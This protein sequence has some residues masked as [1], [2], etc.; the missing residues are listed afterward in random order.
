MN[1]L[2]AR[3]VATRM[4]FFIISRKLAKNNNK[5]TERGLFSKI[6]CGKSC[7]LLKGGKLIAWEIDTEG[8]SV[9]LDC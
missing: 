3:R 5:L 8:M 1:E 6:R 7:Q 2:Y 9:S 4:L